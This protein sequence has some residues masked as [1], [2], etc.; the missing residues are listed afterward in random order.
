MLK[1]V[2][3]K[4]Y[5]LSNIQNKE[6]HLKTFSQ[7]LWEPCQYDRKLTLF[8]WSSL[9]NSVQSSTSQEFWNL[10]LVMNG[11]LM[12]WGR[13]S[14]TLLLWLS[15]LHGKGK[16]DAFF[17]QFSS[18]SSF[19]T[20]FVY[21]WHGMAFSGYPCPPYKIIILDEAD[22]MT[23]DAQVHYHMLQ[24]YIVTVTIFASWWYP[25]FFHRM[26]WGVLWRPIP[27]WQDSSSYAIISAGIHQSVHVLFF[28]VV[29][30]LLNLW[31]YDHCAIQDN[32]A[33]CIKMCK[34]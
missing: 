6:Y 13:R 25:E 24:S 34:V 31:T 15:V 32:R 22:S 28:H 3:S 8:F 12:W 5:T 20:A 2:Q 1:V 11:E 14:K 19:L 16:L 26:R 30:Y 4:S 17:F 21:F 9:D 29:P 27:K 18:D 10:M 7:T 33:T 23:E